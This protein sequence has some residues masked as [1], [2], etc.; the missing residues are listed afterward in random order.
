MFRSLSSSVVESTTLGPPESLSFPPICTPRMHFVLFTTAPLSSMPITESW[1][2][3]SVKVLAV[4]PGSI[5][6]PTPVA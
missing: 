6:A 1:I 4:V 2:Q 3:S 5:A